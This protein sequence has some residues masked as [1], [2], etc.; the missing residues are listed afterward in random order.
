MNNRVPQ[1]R[2]QEVTL[3]GFQ[4]SSSSHCHVKSSG[5]VTPRTGYIT[6]AVSTSPEPVVDPRDALLMTEKQ[7]TA[8]LQKLLENERKAKADVIAKKANIETEL[9]TLSSALF[10]EANKTIAAER[11]KLE[12]EEEL[13]IANDEKEA[14]QSTLRLI[15]S[16]NSQPTDGVG[17][18]H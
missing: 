14:L 16:E 3:N 8:E 9:E 7:R 2:R 18:A 12:A 13:K 17:H 15:E 5:F 6:Y 11:I 1:W 10:E 4:P